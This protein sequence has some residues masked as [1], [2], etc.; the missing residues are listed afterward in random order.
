VNHASPPVPTP[1]TP[2]RLRWLS[3]LALAAVVAALGVWASREPSR[4]AELDYSTAYAW[5]G[6]GHVKAVV[7]SGQSLV[8]ELA[9]PRR[10]GDRS[11]DSFQTTIPPDDDSLIPLLRD[12]AV[13]IRV[14]DPE[15]ELGSTLLALMPWLL[16]IG[17]WLWLSR[18]AQQLT[19]AGGGALGSFLK[20]GHRFEK[21]TAQPVAFADVAGLAAAKRDLE[22]VVQ[23]L[24]EPE[25]FKRLGGKVPRGILLVGPP[26]TGK[27]L[28][29]RAVAGE[30]DVPFYSITGSEFI[31]LFVGV[32]AARVRELFE[33]AKRNAPAIIF[34]DELDSVGRVRG[35]GLG[36]GHDEREQ[37]LNQLLAEMD[38]FDRSDLTVVLAATNRP[39]VLDPAL[40]R[41]GRFDRRVFVD[42]PELAARRELLGL[43]VRGKPV[44]SDV[45]LQALAE[46]TPGFAGADLANLVNEAALH[47]TRRRGDSIERQDFA[48]AYDKI[49]LGEPREGKLTAA[50]KQRVA[51]HEAGHALLA[52]ASPA[53]EPLR[54]VSILPRGM[55]LGAIQQAPDEDR[56]LL[57]RPELDARLRV[58]LG[59]YAA[60]HAV[61]GDLSTGAE[62]DLRRATALAAKM[63]A[64]Y[65]MSEELG[66]VY[67]EHREEHAFLGHRMATDRGISDATIHAVEVETRRLLASA[68]AAARATI[69]AH[70]DAHERLRAALLDR[71]TLER[72]DIDRLL[73]PRTTVPPPAASKPAPGHALLPPR[74]G[75]TSAHRIAEDRQAWGEE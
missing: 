3:W 42:L 46:M 70:R 56:H 45:D 50:E 8:G 52:W 57:T 18:R 44:A 11:F 51:V 26:G 27:T 28:L 60:E 37:T 16:L 55:A 1:A 36:G 34:I 72:D 58:L 7:L 47:A 38:G 35:A 20:R 23:F 21:Q 15:S 5:I 68:L 10:V 24:K 12:K 63:V 13:Q 17:L 73:G 48:A 61:L 59:G 62:D 4:R 22:E 64:H 43:H 49:V 71:E 39:D 67:L 69:E 40:L 19:V 2:R 75:A 31:E 30:A 6:E 54:R 29:A 32:G 14:A 53:A 25:R 74:Y 41:P 65:G 9:A 33:E 66:P